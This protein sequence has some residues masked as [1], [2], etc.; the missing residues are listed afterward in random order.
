MEWNENSS[1]VW[2]FIASNGPVDLEKISISLG[3]ENIELKK[4]IFNLNKIKLIKKLENNTYELNDVITTLDWVN[5]VDF[6]IEI[7]SLEKYVK[8][9]NEERNNAIKI[10]S[11]GTFE[12][13]LNNQDENKKKDYRIYLEG[14]AMTEAAA[15]DLAER[16]DDSNEIVKEWSKKEKDN[17]LN[18]QERMAYALIILTNNELQKTY[19]ILI[20]KL[21]K[22][23]ER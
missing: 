4:I 14:K 22:K 1:I 3:F 19:D 23:S 9:D 20:E 11:D 2:E 17:G 5:A 13:Y 7:S 18:V 6:G 15:T 12:K 8:L 16:L 21:I 10:A